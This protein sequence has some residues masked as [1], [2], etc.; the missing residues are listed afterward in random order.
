MTTSPFNLI[1]GSFA[2]LLFAMF[3]LGVKTVFRNP[4][5]QGYG[6]VLLKV[7]AIAT[8]FSLVVS[9]VRARPVHMI[10]GS[11]SLFVLMISLLLFR[12][13]VATV[14][15]APLSL[16]FSPDAPTTLMDDGPYRWVRHPFYLS[17]L[18]GYV[19]SF[20]AAPNA[21]SLGC[22][23][24]MAGIYVWAARFEEAKFARSPLADAY[25]H[26]RRRTGLVFPRLHKP[27]R[28]SSS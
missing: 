4:G 18:L 27:T 7:G 13:T 25:A 21:V 14:R 10:V 17:Y 26:Y 15:R 19:G 8:A 22:I 9:V 6:Y 16:A 23:V 1:I 11:L 5:G 24:L 3:A 28:G 20:I 2:L 12:W